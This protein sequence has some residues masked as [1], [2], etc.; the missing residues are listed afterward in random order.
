[1]EFDR[2]KRFQKAY[3][4][5]SQE[6]KDRVETALIKFA[7]DPLYPGLHIEKIVPNV[8]SFRASDSLRI[9][10]D[11]DG[12]LK[13]LKTAKS[14]TLRNNE[15]VGIEIFDASRRFPIKNLYSI[16]LVKV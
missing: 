1:M 7:A 2:L 6:D 13:D 16:Q 14:M 9:T 5:L 11:F 4:K 15:I 8:W 3:R 12:Q 10:F